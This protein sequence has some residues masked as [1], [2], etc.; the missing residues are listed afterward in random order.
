MGYELE[1]IREVRIGEMSID[2][3]DDLKI[4]SLERDNE[5]EHEYVEDV[6]PVIIRCDVAEFRGMLRIN[7]IVLLKLI[8]T[9][10]FAI[11][12]CPN[13][14]VVHLMKHHKDDRV[15][16]KN[17]RHAMNLIRKMSRKVS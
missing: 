4:A 14:R 13:K 5:D 16:L 2:I 10:D 3:C 9:W 6:P 7:P 1:N 12:L 8:G 17:Y 15:K 11:E